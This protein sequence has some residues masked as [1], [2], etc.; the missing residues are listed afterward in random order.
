[1][2]TN[3]TIEKAYQEGESLRS[4]RLDA[5]RRCSLVT[6]PTL[7]PENGTSDT[8]ELP[9]TYDSTAARGVSNI[10]A[11][12]T[13][14]V[15]PS[16]G[17]PWFEMLPDKTKVPPGESTANQQIALNH[18]STLV[19]DRLLNTNLRSCYTQSNEKMI[20]GALDLIWFHDD[21]TFSSHSLDDFVL[22]RYPNGKV[23]KFIL[24]E[25]VDP[26]DLPEAWQGI[27]TQGGGQ[28]CDEEACYTEVRWNSTTKKWDVRKEFRGHLVD[29]GKSYEYQPFVF[30]GWKLIPRSHY[31]RSYIE[32]IEGD[33]MFAESIAKSTK[34]AALMAA[35]SLVGVDP[36][37]IT[38]IQDIEGQENGAIVAARK[39]D[40][41]AV[42]FGTATQ[43]QYAMSARQDIRR[44]LQRAFLQAS[45]IQQNKDRQTAEEWKILTAE[46]MGTLG[47]N[48]SSK[49]DDIQHPIIRRAMALM[50]KNNEIPA[51]ILKE[52]GEGGLLKMRIRTGLEALSREV[53]ASQLAEFAGT[54][55]TIPELRTEINWNGWG[56]RYAAAK[57]WDPTDLI[58]TPEQKQA[59]MQQAMQMQVMQQGIQTVSKI[60]ENGSKNA[61]Q[62]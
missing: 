39:D 58:K 46:L 36:S 47:P 49:S 12:I 28:K 15:F 31:C 48:F 60:A 51:E 52:L 29:T 13:D 7:F 30:N 21:F 5:A 3:L 41:F 55:G 19:M 35:K 61:S 62:A 18:F 33:V 43:L 37:G 23:A 34:E 53:E 11:K 44:D 56:L 2:A 17:V 16:N 26:D 54:V 38:E 32:D 50:V 42:N 24:R 4:S 59:E 9:L 57:G 45:S 22:R 27:P 1:M 20:V 25:W 6:I 8:S 14:A 40:V 10:S